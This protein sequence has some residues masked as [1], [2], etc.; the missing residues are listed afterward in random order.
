MS[1][2]AVPKGEMVGAANGDVN[3]I[4][5]LGGLVE[6]VTVVGLEVFEMRVEDW[7]RNED[8]IGREEWRWRIRRI[9]EYAD[10]Q[11]VAR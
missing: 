1:V 3:E 6:L 5:E 11:D 4:G 9:D 7:G 10:N 8:V 2:H